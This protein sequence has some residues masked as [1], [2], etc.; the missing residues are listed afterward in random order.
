MSFIHVTFVANIFIL[1]GM[2]RRL[3]G[4]CIQLSR[5]FKV[6][7]IRMGMKSEKII[8]RIFHVFLL[9]TCAEVSLRP[10]EATWRSLLVVGRQSYRLSRLVYLTRTSSYSICSTP[11]GP[12]FSNLVAEC[13][14]TVA[15]MVKMLESRAV[16]V[17]DNPELEKEVDQNLEPDP[18]VYDKPELG[19]EVIA[20]SVSR[21]EEIFPQS[22]EIEELPIETLVNFPAKPTPEVVPPLAA[23]RVLFFLR[24]PDVYE[25][26][27]TV[28]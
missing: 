21:K 19:L 8:L 23:I 3:K 18:E 9:D 22:I 15:D 4:T 28:F 27:R 17:V 7:M 26:L 14:E 16:K 6:F 1:M 25:P 20:E 13:K 11:R 24:S 12:Q 10:N 5:I 2:K